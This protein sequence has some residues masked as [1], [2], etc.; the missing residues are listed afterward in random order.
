MLG[1]M[2]RKK[3]T[4]EE[5]KAI[6]K[7]FESGVLIPEI[8]KKHSISQTSFYRI[9]TASRGVTPSSQKTGN[10]VKK[11]EKQ[12]REREKE[13]ALLKAALKKS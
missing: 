8:C 10:K 9:L 6:L 1:F 5:I 4:Q 11:L 12:L 3:R 2:P 7:D 13:I